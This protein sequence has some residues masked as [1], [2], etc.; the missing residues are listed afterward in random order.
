MCNKF[1]GSNQPKNVVVINS[2]LN[3]GNN[4]KLCLF[5]QL[6]FFYY[7]RFNTFTICQ[8][9]SCN[10]IWIYFTVIEILVLLVPKTIISLMKITHNHKFIHRS[11]SFEIFER[12]IKIIS[13][14]KYLDKTKRK[15]HKNE[16]SKTCVIN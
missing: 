1:H 12:R 9:Y 11:F 2:H 13:T 16:Y 8:V 7:L 3:V 15:T 4:Y 10:L 6:S 5:L 14:T